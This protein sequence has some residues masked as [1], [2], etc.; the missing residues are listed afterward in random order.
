MSRD[1]AC[2]TRPVTAHRVGIIGLGTVG[3]RFVD[4]FGRHPDFELVAAWDPDEAACAQHAPSVRIAPDADAV[5]DAA[6]VVYVAAP[7][8]FHREYVDAC[9]EAGTAIFC[10][11]PLGV[12]VAESRELVDRVIASGLPAGVNFVF[13]SA[14]SAVGMI[15][16]VRSGELGETARADL[17]LHHASWPR[18]WHAKAQWLRYRDQGGWI[19]EVVSHF[20]FLLGR[21]LGPLRLETAT[22]SYPDGP[23]GT[24]A[25]V[26]GFARFDAGGVP[27]VMVGTSGGTGPDVVDLTIRG[28]QGSVRLWDWYHLQTSDGSAWTDQLGDDRGRLAADAYAAQLGE[29]SRML[30]GEPHRL[31]TFEEAL[32]V[33]ELV[34]AVLAAG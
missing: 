28:S 16:A 10:E 17:R 20:V 30:T 31:A 11:K 5:V 27:V 29:L 4:Q 25:E 19:R 32:V 2:E 18:A 1:V 6:D 8:L 13:S 33:Q 9:V 3:S 15:D 22:V 26:D 23:S 14:P 24:L 34:E 12:D 21:V 7:P